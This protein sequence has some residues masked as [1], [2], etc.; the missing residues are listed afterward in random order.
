[1]FFLYTRY[2]Y[3]KS[4]FAQFL[5]STRLM[6]VLFIAYA[7]AMAVGTFLDAGA[8]TSPTPYSRTL[9]YNAWWFEAIMVLFIVNFFGNIFK[10][11]LI[12][13][14]KWSTL[15]LHLSFVLILIGAA[16]TRYNGF[17]GMLPIKEG[18]SNNTLLSQRV[19][20]KTFVDG[21]FVGKD[22]SLQRRVLPEKELLLSE[23]LDNS[24]VIEEDYKKQDFIEG[25]FQDIDEDNER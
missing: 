20:L 5:F 7:T 23:K 22:G 14:K 2:D 19:Y 17:E 24:F 12:Q 6:A 3:M 16:V 8:E 4:K 1:M 25:E 9:V 15:L 18:E 21:E 11:R 13:Q 10:Y